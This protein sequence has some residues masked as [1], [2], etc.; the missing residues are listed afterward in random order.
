MCVCRG[1]AWE[2]MRCGKRRHCSQYLKG[3]RFVR[4]AAHRERNSFFTPRSLG[5]TCTRLDGNGGL[6]P[7]SVRMRNPSRLFGVGGGEWRLLLHSVLQVIFPYTSSSPQS[8]SPT[9]LPPPPPPHTHTK[10]TT[11]NTKNKQT[12]KTKKQTVSTMPNSS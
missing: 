1:V 5:D 4:G 2:L 11:K 6:N 7:Q 3:V 9:P 12:L 10:T 8:Q